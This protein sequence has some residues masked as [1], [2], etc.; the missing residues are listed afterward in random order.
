MG[1]A[2]S[3]LA[4]PIKHRRVEREL[5]NKVAEALRERAKAR[6]KT[7]RSVNSITMRLPRFKDGLKD[8]RDVF[9]HYGKSRS[10]H[11]KFSIQNGAS[12]SACNIKA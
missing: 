8:I 6:T 10:H 12:E 7:F 9:D 2:A 5:D 11:A 4:A 1:G 3:R